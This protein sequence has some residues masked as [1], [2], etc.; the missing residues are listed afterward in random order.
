[1]SH[2]C[3]GDQ[4]FAGD[5]IDVLIEGQ[6][7]YGT[8]TY[9]IICPDYK[10]HFDVCFP[11][12][13]SC[14]DSYIQNCNDKLVA[15]FQADENQVCAGAVVHF[16]DDSQGN[17]LVWEWHFEGGNPEFSGEINPVVMYDA[18]GLWNVSLIVSNDLYSDTLLFPSFIEAF[19]N[20]EVTLAPFEP[21]CHNSPPFELTGGFPAGGEY[22]GSGVQAGWFDPQVAG[23]GEHVITYFYEDEAGCTGIAEEML[24]VEICT[25]TDESELSAFSV[26]PNPSTGVFFISSDHSGTLLLQV[27]DL[28][29]VT[30]LEKTLQNQKRV[31][32]RID[33]RDFRSGIYM[34]RIQIGNHVFTKKLYSH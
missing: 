31:A 21:V 5:A 34:L 33:M 32:E 27:F 1:V 6:T 30:V 19:A 15:G 8:P 26:Y 3:A 24:L 17:I 23:A 12:E 10:M 28:T 7:F 13:M 25:S 29:G 9:V 22:S 4:G 11:P 18:P 2:P 20:P 16:T 14:F